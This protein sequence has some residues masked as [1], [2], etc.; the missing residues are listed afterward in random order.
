MAAP[1]KA[2]APESFTDALG[3]VYMAVANAKL[4][5]DADLPFLNTLDAI[6]IGRI[7][8]Q[9]QPKPGGAQPPGAAGPPGGGGTPGPPPGGA[10]PGGPPSGG[11]APNQALPRPD[12]DEVRRTVAQ[13]TGA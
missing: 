13:T 5:Q 2:Q 11:M 10:P 3:E 12:M 8:H 4:S 6:L 1:T 7:Q 9:Q